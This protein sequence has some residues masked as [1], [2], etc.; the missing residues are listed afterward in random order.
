M[1]KKCLYCYKSIESNS[2][3]YEYHKN[4]SMKLFGNKK[5]TIL[6]F[7]LEKL[8]ELAIQNLNKR[9]VV[10][11]VQPKLS[12]ELLE[13]KNRNRLTIVGLWGNYI[14]KPPFY[15]Y[16]EMPEIEDLT[17]HLAELA[18]IKSAIHSLIRL[19]SGELGYITKR[20]DRKI[21]N[22]ITYKV[23]TEDF[24][25]LTERITEDKYNS[26]IEK[27][28]KSLKNFSD[29]SGLDLV[30]LFE[31]TIFCFLTGNADMHLK[32][33]SLYKNSKN[34]ITLSPA[35]DLIASKLLIPDDKEESALT[36]N[37][38]KSNLTKNDFI[39]FAK[40]LEINDKVV[41][42][43][44]NRFKLRINELI[45]F[46]DYSFA[47]KEVKEKYSDLLVTRSKRLKLIS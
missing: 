23:Y 25:Q 46:I 10:T 29:Y 24:C 12:L 16:P 42:N 1:K 17:M 26:S 6:E 14:F 34:E 30:R 44:F 20:F 35:Y 3:E 45:H 21:K 15:K 8:E 41:E 2:N 5:P 32:N 27:I 40:T 19:N 43:I 22:K 28:G 4:C 36:F 31:L 13:E 47:S 9:L 38:N 37:G 33:F 39:A 18:G 11:G 7:N